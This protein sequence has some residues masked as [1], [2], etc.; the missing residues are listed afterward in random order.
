MQKVT[1]GLWGSLVV[2]L[3]SFTSV[4]GFPSVLV[5]PSPD[6]PAAPS[7]RKNGLF[8]PQKTTPLLF[9]TQC[10][11]FLLAASSCSTKELKGQLSSP[12]DTP[13]RLELYANVN[14]FFKSG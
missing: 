8:S 7:Q 9:E 6:A 13:S 2:P 5:V 12:M 10:N 1:F 11:W 4:F 3:S 14:A